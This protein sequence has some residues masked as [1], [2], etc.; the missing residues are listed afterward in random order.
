[1]RQIFIDSSYLI[2]LELVTDGNH[3]KALEHW[4]RVRNSIDV[5]VATS[6]VLDETV[7]YFNS[8]NLHAKA[9]KIGDDLLQSSAVQLVQVDENLLRKG[10]IYFKQ[11][12]DKRYS[13]TDCISFI[14]MQQLGIQTALTFDRHFSQAGFIA[15][16]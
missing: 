4:E 14:V 7:T 16:P 2:A 11:H 10:W 13:L 12:S 8:R 9:V 1:M 5:L 6:Y 3:R 15:A